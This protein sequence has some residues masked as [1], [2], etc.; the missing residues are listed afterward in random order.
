MFSSSEIMPAIVTKNEDISGRVAT[1][2]VASYVTKPCYV[3]TRL[4]LTFCDLPG[5]L[6]FSAIQNACMD[7][8]IDLCNLGTVNTMLIVEKLIALRCVTGARIER[9]VNAG[10]DDGV[11][12]LRRARA[13]ARAR[14]YWATTSEIV[15]PARLHF[16]KDNTSQRAKSI[17]GE[18]EEARDL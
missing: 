13:R 14:R 4:S 9:H 16:L 5:Y 12:I 7:M 1:R 8:R 18:I 10:I 6:H 2:R 3:K 15:K 11:Q 17:F